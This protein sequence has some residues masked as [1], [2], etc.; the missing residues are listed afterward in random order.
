[1]LVESD[2][3][4]AQVITGNVKAVDAAG[5]HLL[6]SRVEHVLRGRPEEFDIVFADPPYDVSDADLRACIEVVVHAWTA[7][8]AVLVVERPTRGGE[9]AWPAA[10]EPIKAKRYGTLWYGRRS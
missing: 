2:P 5:A 7:P 1:V 10:V 9:W 3:A 4:A 6:R 8:G